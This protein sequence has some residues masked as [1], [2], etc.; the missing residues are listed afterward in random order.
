MVHKGLKVERER[1]MG[2][3]DRQT[4]RDRQTETDRQTN[5]QTDRPREIQTDRPRER[6]ENFIYIYTSSGPCVLKLLPYF[7]DV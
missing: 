2:E 6:D 4:D 1:R 3:T 5:R 7:E